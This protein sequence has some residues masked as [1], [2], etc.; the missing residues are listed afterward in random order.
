MKVIIILVG[1]F[2]TVS[3]VYERGQEE[4]NIRGRIEFTQNITLTKSGRTLR[5]VLES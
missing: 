3:N 2:G 4:L 1:V 5:K